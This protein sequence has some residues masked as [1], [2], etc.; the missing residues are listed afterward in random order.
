MW[1]RR[2]NSEGCT[3]KQFCSSFFSYLSARHLSYA[4]AYLFTDFLTSHLAG[5][6][7]L[8]AVTRV[9]IPNPKDQAGLIR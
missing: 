3:P 1:C 2:T 4:I 6:D 7:L 9:S 8:A 5:L